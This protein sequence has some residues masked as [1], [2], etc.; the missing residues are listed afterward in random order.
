MSEGIVVRR[1]TSEVASRCSIRSR[2]RICYRIEAVAKVRLCFV[3][4]LIGCWATTAGCSRERQHSPPILTSAVTTSTSAPVVPPLQSA[5]QPRARAAKTLN[6]AL[7]ERD[8]FRAKQLLVDAPPRVSTPVL[9]VLRAHLALHDGEPDVALEQLS[10]VG[11]TPPA[12]HRWLSDLRLDALSRSSHFASHVDE[13]VRDGDFTRL[14]TVCERLLNEGALGR[15]EGALQSLH[16]KAVGELQHGE[17][18]WLRARARGE[19]WKAALAN[20]DVRWLVVHHPSHPRA[21][22]AL[23]AIEEGR[24]RALTMN[25]HELRATTAAEQGL[26]GVVTHALNALSASARFSLARRAYLHGL[27][28]YRARRFRDAVGY[29][30]EATQESSPYR[31]RA[32]YLAALAASRAGEPVDAVRRLSELAGLRYDRETEGNVAFQLGR[33]RAVLGEWAQAAQLHGD[34]VARFPDHTL[35][36]D[37]RREQL[38]AWFAEGN[39]RRF[40]YWVRQYSHQYPD[41]PERLLLRQLEGLALYRLGHREL[42][43]AAWD[44]VARLAPLSFAGIVA[45]QRLSELGVHRQL[46]ITPSST[47]HPLADF[48]I[49]DLVKDLGEV[50]LH[51][52]AEQTMRQLETALVAQVPRHTD[53]A[54]CAAYGTLEY[55]ERRYEIGRAAALRHSVKD[56]PQLAPAWLWPCL[57]PT[58]HPT[59]VGVHGKAHGVSPSLIHAVMRQESGFRRRAVSPAGARGLMQ[60]ITPTAR[61]LAE[62][63]GRSFAMTELFDPHVN[64]QYATYYLSKLQ[65][66]LQHPALVA[67]AYNA[68]PDAVYRWFAAGRTLP[69]EAFVAYIPYDETRVY[70]QRVLENWFV[71]ET[72]N[73]GGRTPVLALDLAEPESNWAELPVTYHAPEELY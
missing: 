29:L 61:R 55:G 39:Y 47:P 8:F 63:L 53:Q 54:L 30:D 32:R 18:R 59:S 72:L 36:T 2:Q 10:N 3:R 52:A 20:P 17:V 44:E 46:P 68:G 35:A 65:S 71:Y 21:S 23:K 66:H 12:L 73:G 15:V 69:L 70:V 25:E 5:F 1:S 48:D 33:E 64:I 56:A 6:M 40:I 43:I 41:A 42:A 13:V 49:P 31:A 37:A 14:A 4:L 51:A 11:A 7:V 34:F 50:G 16:R 26:V 24:F 67:A 28:L 19:Q 57:Y 62:E 9:A 27:A 45:R 60:L 58:P 22:D 38:I